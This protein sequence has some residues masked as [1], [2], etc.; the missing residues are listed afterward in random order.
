MQDFTVPTLS[1]SSS[2]AKRQ[3]N[4]S[5]PTRDYGQKSS[6]YAQ[7]SSLP[8]NYEVK[9]MN[10]EQ[11]QPQEP[12]DRIKRTHIFPP[13]GPS[14]TMEAPPKDLSKNVYLQSPEGRSHSPSSVPF[15]YQNVQTRHYEQIPPPQQQMQHSSSRKGLF[16]SVDNSKIIQE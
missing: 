7:Q 13:R 3:H 6:S 14:V 12:V 4:S 10:Y 9:Y 16:T 1:L 11:Y 8:P 15:S 2:R 5:V